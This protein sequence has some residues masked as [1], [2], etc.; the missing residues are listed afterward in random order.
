[1]WLNA[2]GGLL[3]SDGSPKPA[4]DRLRSLVKGEWWLDTRAIRTDPDGRLTVSGF[5]GDYT[6][7]P[8][9]PGDAPS[10]TNDHGAFTLQ[11]PGVTSVTLTLRRR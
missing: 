9:H 2:P 11:I 10:A 7:R 6:A 3:R 1:M 5:L 4:Y 8:A